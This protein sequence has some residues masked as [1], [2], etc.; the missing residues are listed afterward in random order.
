MRALVQILVR[1]LGAIAYEINRENK[2]SASNDPAS[3]IAN[4]G[5]VQQSEQSFEDLARKFEGDRTE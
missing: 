4:G 3:T 5:S 1:L 2:E